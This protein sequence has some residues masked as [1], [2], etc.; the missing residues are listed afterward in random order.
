MPDSTEIHGDQKNITVFGISGPWLVALVAVILA[1]VIGLVWV[2]ITLLAAQLGGDKSPDPIIV[3]LPPS[4]ASTVVP[5]NTPVP[6]PTTAPTALIQP[7]A[8]PSPTPTPTVAPTI[9][10]AA[11]VLPPAP[12]EIPAPTA[13]SIPVPDMQ[14]AVPQVPLNF[15]PNK[16]MPLTGIKILTRDQSTNYEIQ[17]DWGDG[18]SP[19]APSLVQNNGTVV[20]V[21]SYSE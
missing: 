5:T 11:Q 13:T 16:S 20:A 6:T 4:S 8:L 7:T 14:I 9:T 1:G 19:E 2:L 17:I 18:T 15:D 10:V 12:T 3:S 21:H